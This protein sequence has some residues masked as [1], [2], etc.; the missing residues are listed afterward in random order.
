MKFGQVAL[1]GIAIAGLSALAHAEAAPHL[2]LSSSEAMIAGEERSRPKVANVQD[3]IDA[4]VHEAEQGNADAM[5]LLGVLYADGAAVTQDYSR[6]LYWYLKAVD[7]GS[8]RA[9]NN[10]ATLYLY[11]L[12]VPQD[13]Q[14]AASWFQRAADQGSARAMNSLGVMAYQGLGMERNRQRAHK[15]YQR[16]AENGLVPAMLNLSDSY[17]Q[18]QGVK[19][20][21][22]QAY[23]WLEV[24]FELGLPE[25]LKRPAVNQL[26]TL[27]ARPGQRR[28]DDA[29]LLAAHR[30]KLV[31]ERALTIESGESKVV[32][33]SGF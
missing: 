6:S 33:K 17:E 13:Y 5:N 2:A 7:H 9:M 32:S 3:A 15:M 30:A 16:A 12:G 24:A 22:L 1:A 31:R 25:E 26:N 20:D 10:V 4:Y 27:A 8:T 11:G 21:L 23:V 19:R 29:Q 28:R 18:G 14:R